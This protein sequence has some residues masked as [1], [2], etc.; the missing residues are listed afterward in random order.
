MAN[1]GITPATKGNMLVMSK[2]AD[3]SFKSIEGFMLFW[4]DTPNKGKCLSVEFHE[5]DYPA[6]V[7]A[8]EANWKQRR[9]IAKY[10]KQGMEER[11][12]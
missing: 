10:R 9:H 6:V 5:I 1:L 11:I 4:F 3:V 7:V 2:H 12:F 8:V